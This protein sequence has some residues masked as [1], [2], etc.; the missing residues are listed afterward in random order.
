MK[1]TSVFFIVVKRTWTPFSK[2]HSAEIPNKLNR[3][4]DQEAARHAE[5]DAVCQQCI[6]TFFEAYRD[7]PDIPE[8]ITFAV[9]PSQAGGIFIKYL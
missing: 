5:S 8:G 1:S 2:A 3:K 4:Y 7:T 9:T 6:R